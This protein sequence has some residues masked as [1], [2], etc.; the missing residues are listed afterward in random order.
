MSHRSKRKLWANVYCENRYSRFR[1]LPDPALTS[2]P[3][4]MSHTHGRL[5]LLFAGPA[6]PLFTLSG[7]F[8]LRDFP[9]ATSR[10]RHSVDIF[11]SP[12]LSPVSS[13]DIPRT[14]STKTFLSVKTF[15][16]LRRNKQLSLRALSRTENYHV[17]VAGRKQRPAAGVI[18]FLRV[19]IPPTNL[20]KHI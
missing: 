6:V 10:Y 2:A 7:S 9:S 4:K 17:F 5:I 20:Q 12:S 1:K 18:K 14:I 8:Y 13:T 3:T 19:R 16:S 15:P 11:L